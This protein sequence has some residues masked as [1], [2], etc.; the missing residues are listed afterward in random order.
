MCQ[1][2]DPCADTDQLIVH[3]RYFE[4][5]IRAL[6]LENCNPD[7]FLK[8]LLPEFEQHFD[9]QFLIY[10]DGD[11]TMDELSNREKTIFVIIQSNAD[12]DDIIE[13]TVDN[14]IAEE[15]R[16]YKLSLV[17]KVKDF[18]KCLYLTHAH[19]IDIGSAEIF[20]FDT[21]NRVN[22]CQFSESAFS[23]IQTLMK[24]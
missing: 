9:T 16:T 5:K 14:L 15:K 10:K 21:L 3:Y 22:T 23:P 4:E 19:T 20:P 18:S 1:L 11:C 13:V 24:I 2:N 7:V 6:N 8:S 17:M 12:R